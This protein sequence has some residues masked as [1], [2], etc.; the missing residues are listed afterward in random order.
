MGDFSDPKR[1]SPAD[2]RYAT[3]YGQAIDSIKTL[4]LAL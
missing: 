4:Q 2:L 1:G 3:V